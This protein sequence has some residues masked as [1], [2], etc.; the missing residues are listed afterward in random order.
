MLQ[1]LYRRIRTVDDSPQNDLVAL[2][3]E[4]LL[5][6]NRLVSLT[7]T[8]VRRTASPARTPHRGRTH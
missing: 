3:Y 7:L 8:D 6:L 4:V 5:N 2:H 1:T